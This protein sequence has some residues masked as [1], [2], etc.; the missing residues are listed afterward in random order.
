MR[1]YQYKKNNPYWLRPKL[2]QRVRLMVEEYDEIKLALSDII[3]ESPAP[4]GMPRGNMPADPTANKA[5]RAELLF[6]QITAIEQG[7]KSIPFFYRKGVWN[8]A[9]HGTPFPCEGAD[10]STWY[11]YQGRFLYNIAKILGEI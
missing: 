1:N 5:V 2:Y 6:N 10:R 11:R 4:D 9:V 7:L 8:H 3:E